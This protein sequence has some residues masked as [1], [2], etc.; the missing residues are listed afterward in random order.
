MCRG[1]SEGVSTSGANDVARYIKLK[2]R[3]QNCTY[4]DGNLEIK[5]LEQGNETFD[6][7][8]LS[9][10]EEVSGYVLI[11]SVV[12]ETIPLTSLKIIRGNQLF[13]YKNHSY[14]LFVGVNN[15]ETR[16]LKELLLT[17]LSGNSNISSRVVLIKLFIINILDLKAM[18][19]NIEYLI[20]S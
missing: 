20:K 11:T 17:N 8:F 7:S 9:K 5:F 16:G 15:Q 6:L 14:S 1:S 18:L 2:K 13:N 10:I 12:A 3:Y 4:V 19:L